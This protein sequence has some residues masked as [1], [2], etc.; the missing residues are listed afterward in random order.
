MNIIAI[1][2]ATGIYYGLHMLWYFPFAFGNLWLKLI[3]KEEIP[4]EQ[5]IKESIIMVFTAL[6]T[7]FILAYILELTET[8]EIIIGLFITIILYA[9]FVVPIAI[10]QALFTGRTNIK[11]FFIEYGYYLI[12]FLISGTIISLWQ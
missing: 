4:K 10:N 11:L 12:G 7:N 2:I 5:I 8:T 9:G 1:L 6:A 3:G